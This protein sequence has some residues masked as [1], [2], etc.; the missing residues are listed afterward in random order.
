[1]AE[2][3]KKMAPDA[4]PAPKKDAPPAPILV[5]LFAHSRYMLHGAGPF[6]KGVVYECT[7][8]EAAELLNHT[9]ENGNPVFRKYKAPPPVR[10]TADGAPVSKVPTKSSND[11]LEAKPGRPPKPAK[12]SASTPEEDAEIDALVTE[13]LKEEGATVEV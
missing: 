7:P 5:E 4:T 6:E 2:I 12:I 3:T 13:G 9:G 11:S 8:S 1:M 10:T